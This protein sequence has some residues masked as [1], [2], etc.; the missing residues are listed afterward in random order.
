MNDEENNLLEVLDYLSDPSNPRETYPGG[1]VFQAEFENEETGKEVVKFLM[2][3]GIESELIQYNEENDESVQIS[4]I[5]NLDEDYRIFR[6]EIVEDI[7][8]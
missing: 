4:L 7:E 3:Y 2:E 6:D 5:Y 1:L 8:E